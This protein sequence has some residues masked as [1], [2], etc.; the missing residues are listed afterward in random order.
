MNPEIMLYYSIQYIILYYIILCQIMLSYVVL[1]Y[2]ILCNSNI[3]AQRCLCAPVY[4]L[5]G[6]GD[7]V[8][9]LVRSG[10]DRGC[11]RAASGALAVSWFDKDYSIL[12]SFWGSPYLGKLPSDNVSECF[13]RVEEWRTW[14]QLNLGHAAGARKPL[15]WVACVWM[16]HAIRCL[17]AF[18]EPMPAYVTQRRR[19]GHFS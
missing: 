14:Q 4:F 10:R 9:L 19:M 1:Y 7:A 5:K 15:P 11:F 17:K 3:R 12:G 6:T 18:A 13:C 8:A 2:G 16:S